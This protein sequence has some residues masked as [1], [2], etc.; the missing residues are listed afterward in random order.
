MAH[1]C[2]E[3]IEW[4]C[5]YVGAEEFFGLDLQAYLEAEGDTFSSIEWTLPNGIVN[6][7][8]TV[9]N[10]IAYIKIQANYVGM[11]VVRFKLKSVE[12]GSTQT[13]LGKA[14]LHVDNY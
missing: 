4:P 2:P 11:H 3:V 7:A 14:L 6:L 13:Y 9:I 10:N 5:T 12:S 8:E 1:N